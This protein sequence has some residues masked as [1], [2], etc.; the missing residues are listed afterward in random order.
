MSMLT[1]HLM[2]EP[3]LSSQTDSDGEA[4]R[5]YRGMQLPG[6]DMLCDEREFSTAKQVQSAVHQFGREAVKSVTIRVCTKCSIH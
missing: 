4:M 2:A 5:S 3:T 1:G 6:I